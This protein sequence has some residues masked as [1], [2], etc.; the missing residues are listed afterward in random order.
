MSTRPAAA[1]EDGCVRD[2]TKPR[3]SRQSKAALRASPPH[4]A[5]QS[6]QSSLEDMSRL[7][8]VT[9]QLRSE[10]EEEL[11]WKINQLEKDKLELT[12][13]YNQEVSGYEAQLA[14]LR[15]LLERGEAN[16]QTLE[17]E[18]AV[19]RR[20]A[21]VQKSSSEDRIA[22]LRKHNQQLKT[23]SAE[24]SQRLSDLERALEITRQAR[25]ED[26]QG[27][28]AELHE[29][30]RLLLSTSAD[31]DQLQAE[32]RRLEAL[33]QE[34][35]DT[36]KELK[37]KMDR[38]QKERERDAEE[39]RVKTSELKLSADREE[40]MRTEVESAMQRMKALEE[41]VES[42]RAAHL[43][44]KF[45]SEIIQLRLR[46]LEAAL[47]VEKSSQAEAVS[48]L[49]LLRQNFGEVEKAYTRER[50][51]ATDTHH[52]LQQLEK[53]YLSTKTELIGQLDKEKATSAE[54]IGRLEQE[55]AESVKLSLRL[56]EQERVQTE[57]QHS[58]SLVQKKLVWVEEAH[59]AL[60]KEMEQ[61]L[62]HYHHLGAP[63]IN[64]TGEGDEQSSF[65]LMDILRR[66]LQHYHT[67]LKDLLKVVDTLKKESKEKEKI[68]TEQRRHIQ[69]CEG[70]CVCLGEEVQRLRVSVTEAADRAQTE[71]RSVTQRWEE[72]RE[73]HTHTR[74]QIHTLTQEHERDQQEK[75]AFLHSLYQQLVAGCVLVS[76][77]Q[78]MLGSFS[79]VELSAVLQ[80]HVDALTSDL[81]SANQKISG[82][83]SV[84]EGKAAA[85]ASVCE[86]LKQREESWIRQRKELDAHHSQL[87]SEFQTRVQDLRRKLD[88]A[89]E[90][91]RVLERGRSDLEQE[92]T[93]LQDLVSVCR[94]DD[95]SLLAACA[96]LAGCVCELYGRVG[97]LA[98]Q[99]AALWGRV[100]D[101]AALEREVGS[102]LQALSEPEARGQPEVRGGVRA[103]RRCVIAVL[104][105]L[106]L[107]ALQRNSRR[108]FRVSGSSGE[109]PGVCVWE[110]RLREGSLRRE[111]EEEE[112]KSVR[113]MKMLR[114]SE[115][116]VLIHSCM[117]GVQ[118]ELDKAE[119][120]SAVLNAAQNSFSK[121]LER[122][123]SEADPGSWGCCGNVGML[124]RLLGHGLQRLHTAHHVPPG[125]YTSK[126][127]VSS[128]QQHF[129]VFTQRLHSAEVERRELRLELSR[130]KRS[131]AHARNK[132][133]DSAHT[134][135]VPVDQ[136]QS[137]C[138]ELSSA[139]QREQEVQAL[140]HDQATQL[141]ELGLTMELHTGD[142]LE[143]DR[144]LAQAV[145]SLSEAKAELKRKEQSLRLLGKRLSQSQQEKQ[146]LQQSI[147]SAE[148][149]LRMAAK[150]K[151]SFASYVKS[152]E[153]SLKELK[154]RIILS[155]S[156]TS[157]E[158]FTLHLPHTLVDVSGPEW[159]TGGP[160][161]AACQTLVRSFLE[162]YQLACSKLASL[163]REISSYQSHITALKAELQDA[164]LRENQTY[165][166]VMGSDDHALPLFEAEVDSG[167]PP[168]SDTGVTLKDVPGNL[169]P[170][171]SVPLKKSKAVKK[172]SKNTKTLKSALKP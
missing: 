112:E 63:Q 68:I 111:R 83:E 107:R 163:E 113:V 108:L 47:S 17:Y 18:V 170:L 10:R 168:L 20:D 136:F 29:R 11:R 140:L 103:F 46:D 4:L 104:A 8:E 137:V 44:S 155:R 33:L 37:D 43:E 89:E 21:A 166:P 5:D 97:A 169:R 72:E 122:L 35:N 49:E 129:L 106:R 48:N 2:R 14:R 128:L 172:G 91:I 123:L 3:K 95:A 54:L 143:K 79:W 9:G 77:P 100:C 98:R 94:R 84:C 157:R 127:M 85:L 24:L 150:N 110:V 156:S 158:D 121:L 101:G 60:L 23:L 105:A 165:V 152:V 132:P 145:Q 160:E 15:A 96:L 146:Q 154:D 164:C 126:C 42:E 115:L 55:R 13:K 34:Q 26:Q 71:L 38:V 147:T 131:T 159:S 45:N 74:A 125:R 102:L 149:A 31:N 141:Q 73:R 167:T 109:S 87:T 58:L 161:I 118:Q 39:L 52:K 88:Q 1:R 116:A 36:L 25:E 62:Q 66:T 82:L 22:D 57:N 86:Q 40:R 65:A 16:R 138:A 27:L 78:S 139:L 75:L 99:K 56:Q 6:T 162:V 61:L 30:D 51:R 171:Q 59:E 41:N 124:A 151:D 50:D 134:T 114:S 7:R 133:R 117:Q 142:Q 120:S 12:S 153:S 53:E 90:S 80:E 135:C 130:L 119:L 93:R 69:E 81:S 64:N 67:E 32:R 28:Q 19:A 76:P 92:V 148:N 70:Q 144:T